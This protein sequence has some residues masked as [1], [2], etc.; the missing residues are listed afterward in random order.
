LKTSDDSRCN[1]H[2]KLDRGIWLNA[3]LEA[4]IVAAQIDAKEYKREEIRTDYVNPMQNPPFS[5]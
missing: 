5:E 2:Q 3:F 4:G 1:F